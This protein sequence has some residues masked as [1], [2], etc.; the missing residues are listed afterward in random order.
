MI[1]KSKIYMN[2]YIAGVILGVVIILAFVITGQGVGASG[3]VKDA[4]STV[5][6]NVAHDYAADADYYHKAA[7]KESSP[8][9]TWLVFEIMGV[10]FGGVISGA[11]SGRLKLKVERPN[12]VSSRKRI[13][14][15]ILGGILFGIGSQLARGC[16]SG[17]G[18][19]GMAVLSLSGFIAAFAMFGGGFLFAPFFRKLWYK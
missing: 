7:E 4:T 1:D 6:I 17:A 11:M 5:V 2:P 8:M 13:I 16:A 12:H 19:S 9:K 14:F 15:A 3:A 10:I 18:L